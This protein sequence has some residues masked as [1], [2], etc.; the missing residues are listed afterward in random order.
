M[1][2]RQQLFDIWGALYP[3]T[4]H[5][6]LENFLH[7][8][9]TSCCSDNNKAEPLD[10][11]KDAIVYSLYVDLF[12]KDFSG[13]TE[14]LD[15][16]HD[17][18]VNCLWLLPILESPMRDAGFDISDY[19]SIRSEL[20]GNE[21][22]SQ[23]KIFGQLLTEAHNRGI[24]V[25]FDF[26]MNHTSDQ[27]YWF[28]EARK[29][30]DNPYRNYF[31]WE[32][33]TSKYQKARIIF[34]GIENSNWERCGDEYF[35]HRFFNF[36]PDLNYRNPEVLLSM[37]RNL[38]FW[39]Q[40]GVDGF[41]VDAI[42]YIWKEEGTDCENLPQTHLIVK[43]LRAIL[44]FVKPGSLLLAEACQQPAKV[45]EY[46]GDGDECHAAY[47][48]PLM[49]R[50]FKAIEQQSGNPIQEILSREVTPD[51][52]ESGQWF[53]FLRCHDELSLELVYV[54]EEERKY[55]H[56]HYCR[57]PKWDFRMGEGISARLSELLS[58]DPRKIHLAY[59][60][61][62]TL[63]GT[64]VIYYGDEFGKLNDEEYYNEM[65]KLNGK[66]DTR[67]LVR[68]KIDWISLEKELSDPASF[69]SIINTKLKRMLKTRR[70]YRAFGRGT[71]RFANLS[72][73][74]AGA[75][76]AYER[77]FL[78]EKI[79]VVHNMT[80]QPC[81]LQLPA[82]LTSGKELLQQSWSTRMSIEPYGFR[83][84]LS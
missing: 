77:E 18:G 17:L 22:D 58:R 21:P 28:T 15:Y 56:E 19:Y 46:M 16:I 14:K 12:N 60:L 50:M 33:D 68:G 70:Q 9:P 75:I 8:L 30:A 6:I 83:W 42:P 73:N 52:P 34:K 54:T 66:D 55:I 69:S 49:P 41:R 78:N 26:A 64:P 10:W 1:Q 71:I 57:N 47:H 65:I 24:R 82:T 36:Q 25:I 29:S 79:L 67:F 59:S 23:F 2:L 84:I 74:S 81:E 43:F 76:L 4:S 48:F 39:Q 62:L 61:I 5:R 3:E 13:L 63:P 7:T 37:C 44:D 32:K 40:T 53:T 20:L 72:G 11:Y 51:L 45:V 38:L 35:F 80:D 27:H 31:I